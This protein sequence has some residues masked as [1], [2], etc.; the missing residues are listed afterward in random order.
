MTPRQQAPG[1]R[2]GTHR[3]VI[4]AATTTTLMALTLSAQAIEIPT[5]N[6]DL[7]LRWDNTLRYNLAARTQRQDAALIGNPN[8]DDGDRNFAKN[9]LV[10]NRL[11][12]LS[13]FDLTFR[14]SMG[15]RVSA[16][17]WYDDA[18]RK[19]SG[20][21]AS[22]ATS[23]HL[24]GGVQSLGYNDYVRRFYKGASGE[25]LDA[26]AFYRGDLGGNPFSLKVGRSVEYWGEALLGN[27]HAVSYSQM[28]L[29]TAKALAIPGIEIKEVFRPIAN[30]TARLTPTDTITLA[31]QYFF[32]WEA[33]RLPEPGTYLGPGDS[34]A[35]SGEV[36]LLGPAKVLRLPDITPRKQGEYGLS[37]R[38]AS[39]QLDATVGLYYRNFA[40]KLGQLHLANFAGP[41]PKNY[42]YAFADRID[43][44]GLSVAKQVGSASV[45]AEL[46]YRRNMPL[47]SD[48]VPVLS[49]A[50][51][52]TAGHTNG[53]RGNTWHGLVNVV[54]VLPGSALWDS[55]AVTG[56]LYWNRWDKVTQGIQYFK[57]RDAAPA[58]SPVA[59]AAYTAIDRVSRDFI[60][61]AVGLTPTWLQVLPGVDLSMPISVSDGLGG[62]SAVI[63]GGNKDAGSWSLALSADIDQKHSLS[64]RYS[65]YFGHYTVAANGVV[66]AANGLT[67][68]LRDRGFVSLTF[69]TTF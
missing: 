67:A 18:Y 19:T 39:P 13:E 20:D 15:L 69:K 29:D 16:A 37:M 11:D 40:D 36:L 14:K 64:L 65:G 58:G 9:A 7:S 48:S 62:N 32:D 61:V 50:A 34:I 4:A 45:G 28:P 25:L 24:V 22:V 43:L 30:I 63:S 44:V 57:G 33:T 55:M 42:V 59:Y 52:P 31:A 66:A 47:I 6:E 51:M 17:G 54:A 12:L 49:A 8:F 3:T 38:W 26:F 23:N 60:G 35:N 68:L 1:R 41:L 46:S 53:A 56:E 27:T 5:G 10:A 2:L 21:N